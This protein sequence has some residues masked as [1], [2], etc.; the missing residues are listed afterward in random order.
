MATTTNRILIIV[1][2]VGEYEKVGYRTGLWL[3]ELT[4]FYDVAEQAGFACTV[5]SIK[6]G[7]V[8]LDPESLAHD[9]LGEL[10]TDKRYAERAPP[11]GA[12]CAGS[13][14]AHWDGA[15]RPAS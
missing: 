14:S 11:A 9:V 1:T 7:H 5:A 13:S 4:H 12:R 10:G 8:P 15:T 2:S 3:G 6:G